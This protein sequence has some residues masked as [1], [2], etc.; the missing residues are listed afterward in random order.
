MPDI[1]NLV[2]RLD[3][4]T[5]IRFN[6]TLIEQADGD[7]PTLLYSFEGEKGTIVGYGASEGYWVKTENHPTKFGAAPHEFDVE[8]PNDQK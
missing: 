4:G 1:L 6:Q 8:V 3:I 5:R 7:H 2:G